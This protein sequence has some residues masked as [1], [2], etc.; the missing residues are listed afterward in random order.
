LYGGLGAK[1]QKSIDL[2]CVG[3]YEFDMSALHPVYT[4]NARQHKDKYKSQPKLL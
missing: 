1:I 4:L 2:V 3:Q